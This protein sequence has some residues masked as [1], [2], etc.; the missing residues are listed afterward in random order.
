MSYRKRTDGG[1]TANIRYNKREKI[2]SL[3][4]VNTE[5]LPNLNQTT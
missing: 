4:E 2:I 5:I 1:R 3:H